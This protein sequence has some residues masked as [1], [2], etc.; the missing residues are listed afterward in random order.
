MPARYRP[1]QGV[2]VQK[3][4]NS[5]A[6]KYGSSRLAAILDLQRSTIGVLAMV[7]LVGRGGCMAVRFLPIY[8]LA[9]GGGALLWQISPQAN[10]VTAFLFGVIGTIGLMCSGGMYKIP[11]LKRR[12]RMAEDK[13]I[14]SH[15]TDKAIDRGTDA[16]YTISRADIELLRTSG[17][18]KVEPQALVPIMNRWPRRF[19]KVGQ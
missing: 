10:F 8:I 13:H 5:K 7:V 6:V 3:V 14:D 4:S 12:H 19:T 2:T 17:V 9:L 15:G 18:S 16:R 11:S 1:E